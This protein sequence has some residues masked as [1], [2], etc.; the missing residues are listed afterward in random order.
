MAE[1]WKW[2]Q[3]KSL[4]GWL[5][6]P[7]FSVF[8]IPLYIPRVLICRTLM[9]GDMGLDLGFLTVCSGNQH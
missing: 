3:P 8:R 5:S 1:A 9:K 7:M 2:Y 4:A 6:F